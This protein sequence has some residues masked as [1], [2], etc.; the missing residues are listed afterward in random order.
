MS[1]GDKL[2]SKIGPRVAELVTQSIL[3][4]KAQ[5]MEQT[6]R[7]ITYTT[8]EI[9]RLVSSQLSFD[10]K[11]ILTRLLKGEGVPEDQ[12]KLVEELTHTSAAQTICGKLL[13]LFGV[14]TA[15]R[16]MGEWDWQERIQ[17]FKYLHPLAKIDPPTA[18]LAAATTVASVEWCRDEVGFSGY[19]A[20]RFDLLYD[21]SCRF[22]DVGTA[23]EIFRR[24]LINREELSRWLRRQAYPEDVV[25]KLA[26]L[27]SIELSGEVLA[28]AYIKGWLELGEALKLADRAGVT[29]EQ[30]D[31]LS[32]IAGEPPGL[33]Q[34]LEAYRRKII[35]KE[36]LEHGIRESRVRN[37]WI[38]VVEA[39]RYY[40]PSPA[41]CIEGA[42]KGHLTPEES[43]AKAERA[44]LDPTEWQ[45]MFETHGNPPGPMEMIDLWNRGEVTEERVVE[46]LKQ[47][48]L[49]N[50]FIPDVLK[51]KRRL[52][53][54]GEVIL[55]MEAGVW[56]K[57][58]AIRYLRML[59]YSP[60][61]AAD[62]A[63]AGS[64]SKIREDW[65]IAKEYVSAQYEL[66]LVGKEDAIE[67]LETVGY[68]R[69]EAEVIVSIAE[70]KRL[71]S[72]QSA[73]I[74]KIRSLYVGYKIDAASCRTYLLSLR[75]PA[76]QVG[77][78]ME[79]WRLERE[80]SI[81]TL[82][83]S[84]IVNAWKYNIIDGETAIAKL[85]EIGYTEE[86]AYILISIANKGPLH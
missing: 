74:E 80:A 21:L 45:W 59:G 57:D 82:T 11:A 36:R 51:L 83:E 6:S 23:L 27:W 44:G 63:A 18:A 34:L 84:Q 52:P 16:E 31:I 72:Q 86:D 38:D 53:A 50:R 32:K 12:A 24:H 35:D 54:L 55:L 49:A 68:E 42:V 37:E 20:R 79:L 1:V 64:R 41:E 7:L 14:F 46:A 30:F 65:H 81:K 19:D 33:M 60:D 75:I 4:T 78:I 77:D 9:L 15:A 8:G 62:I 71:V 13:G 17:N 73:A 39:L 22:P 67:T 43:K 85:Q 76:E 48:H 29:P 47:G 66:G 56:D 2:G 3:S 26:H 70:L 25:D 69:D 28:T 61:D 58:R 40:P 10:E 5:S